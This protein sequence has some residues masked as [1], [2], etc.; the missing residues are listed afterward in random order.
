MDCDIVLVGLNHRT[1][2]VDVRE[3]FALVDFCAPD[4]WAIPCNG[5]LNEA[6]ILSTCNRVELLATGSGDVAGQLLH[7]WAAARKADVDELRNY[8]YIHKNL[9]AVRHLF[10]VASSLDSMVLGEPQILG[11]LKGAYRKA[12]AAHSVGVILNRLLH[13]AFSVAK[14][15]RTE[16]AVA[17]SAVSISYAAVE[18]AKR[19]F[20]DMHEH[21]AML[22]GAGEMA[23]LA[24]THLLQA[25]VREIIVA[26]R[27]LARGQ[28]LAA[29]FHGRAIPFETLPQ[30]LQ[31]VDIIITSTG[32]PDPVIRAR[33]IRSVLKVRKNRPMFFID[34]AVPRD[35]DPDVNS[36]DNVYLYDIDDLKEVV[37]ENLAGRRD[38][39][40]KAEAIVEEEVGHFSQWTQSLDIQPTIVDIIRRGEHIAQ[41]EV[42]KTLK[43]LGITD[44][45]T[46]DALNCMA[47]A[48]VSKLNH[49]PIMFLK[50]G[51]MSQDG[52]APR[53]S[54]ARRFF[55]LDTGCT[56]KNSPGGS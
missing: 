1:A 6:L 27:T 26:N 17:S 11:Q 9:D 53:I 32:S 49:D 29:Q 21:S 33:D 51:T 30:Y 28:E 13:K 41:E 24:A 16:T 25:G 35:I 5:S 12:V 45:E 36:L 18:L 46:R 22:V 44:E 40:R 10:T 15:V 3:R 39:A 43:R 34:I 8:V 52:I 23:E 50:S 20:G 47:H 19:I 48:I 4:T 42:A 56:A 38:E 54:L 2:G 55:N 31:D 37:E 7:D 14:R